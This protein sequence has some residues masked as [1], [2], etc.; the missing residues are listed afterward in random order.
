LGLETWFLVAKSLYCSVR[1][2]EFSSRYPYGD[3]QPPITPAPGAMAPSFGLYWHC[4]SAVYI[5]SA[6]A[7]ARARAHTHTHTHTHTY[8]NKIT[9]FE[10]VLTLQKEGYCRAVV[11]HA[12]NP[13]TWEA[14]AGGF[15][16]SRP[17]WSTE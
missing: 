1:E 11:A 8:T 9:L 6:C 17:A 5:N 3:S 2:P 7:R 4:T 14:E 12:F 15:L 16:S 10:N 13:S